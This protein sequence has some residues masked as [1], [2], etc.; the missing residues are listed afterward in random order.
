MGGKRE[1]TAIFA[2]GA[3]LMGSF[4]GVF[5]QAQSRMKS[6][7]A[8]ASRVSASVKSM[9]SVFAGLFAGLAAFGAAEI[10]KR[11]FTNASEEATA[12]AQRTRRMTTSLLQLTDIAKKGR[13]YAE[14]QV[15]QLREHNDLLAKQQVY[16]EEI[17]DAGITQMAVSAM[18]PKYIEKAIG[19]LT[20]VLALSRG[21]SA[22]QEDMAGLASAFGRAVKTGMARPL[23]EFGIIISKP[24]QKLISTMA[25]AGDF[26]G[27]YN[28]L[29]RKIA[30][31]HGEAARLMATPGGRIKLLQNDMDAMS[32][33]LGF[34]MKPA[35]AAMADFWRA[36]LPSAERALTSLIKAFGRTFSRFG[37]Q[38]KSLQEIVIGFFDWIT[39]HSD[40]V[41]TSIEAIAAALGALI[42][43]SAG[44]TYINVIL[45]GGAAGALVEL[46]TR[47]KNFQDLLEKRPGT[48]V[49]P[50]QFQTH[51]Y[52]LGHTWSEA[53]A[54]W[55]SF[56]NDFVAGLE[57]IGGW[58]T[59]LKEMWDGFVNAIKTFSPP[60]WWTTFWDK[61]GEAAKNNP[62][63]AAAAR[64]Q[65]AGAAADADRLKAMQAAWTAAGGNKATGA[66]AAAIPLPSG[67]TPVFGPQTFVPPQAPMFLR[68]PET[69]VTAPWM[70]A[71]H[72]VMSAGER[73]FT[74]WREAATSIRKDASSSI[75][76]AL[77]QTGDAIK[78]FVMRPIQDVIQT[79]T[80]LQTLMGT[81][82]A[83]PMTV[84]AT[85]SGVPM[86][87][88]P[89]DSG[90]DLPPISPPAPTTAPD[91]SASATTVHFAPNI[92]IHGN[93]TEDE[94]RAMDSKLR[95][96]SRDFVA[97]FNKA[98]TEERRLSYEG[99]YG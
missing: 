83:I 36:V 82:L 16:G 22:T 93:A 60:A 21:V 37:I 5:A 58:I 34:M 67:V 24:E 7:Q 76:S 69:A 51:W 74:P 57:R 70:E 40:A 2:I 39:D 55:D 99:G 98:Q 18:P 56:C 97:Q 26:M 23:R 65:A 35:Q 63:A 43:L 28:L 95:D 94:Q 96:L 45:A 4:R 92:T 11:I 42:L 75:P 80:T 91:K 52:L 46:T 17:L 50:A 87:L 59:K 66:A 31:A 9:T 41:V 90:V 19:P 54:A 13:G 71:A 14:D 8:T 48:I 64:E 89:T 38:T 73:A 72:N 78:N 29:L 84:P 27:V 49:D 6:L 20:D 53:S 12:A 86:A 10:F 79:W 88:P 61:Q 68:A 77:S 33:R 81:P 30:F 85:P 44:G 25:K 47:Y 1:Y 15:R 62:A 32:K 3:K